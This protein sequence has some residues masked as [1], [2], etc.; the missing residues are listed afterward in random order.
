MKQTG[1]Y[2]IKNTKKI[3]EAIDDHKNCNKKFAEFEMNKVKEHYA[4]TLEELDNNIT[5]AKSDDAKKEA[6]SKKKEFMKKYNYELHLAKSSSTP[7]FVYTLYLPLFSLTVVINFLSES[8][9]TSSTL[10]FSLTIAS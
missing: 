5:N 1:N 9:G 2:L 6:I 3:K 7:P 8:N 4:K 10:R